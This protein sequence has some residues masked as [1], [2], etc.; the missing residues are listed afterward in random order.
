MKY[1]IITAIMVLVA[2]CSDKPSASKPAKRQTFTDVV[3][4]QAGTGPQIEV[5]FY[6]GPSLYYPLM[7]VWLED[8]QGD[9][10]QTLFV[11]RAIATGVFKYGSNASGKWEEAAKRAPQTLPY[12]SHRRGIR[13]SDGLYMPDP[14][15][16]V[17]D[18]YSGA[19]PTTS[20][21]LQ[22]RA[23]KAL[24]GKFRVMFEVN[25]NWDWNEYWTNDK[26]PDDKYYLSNAQPSLVYESLIDM[27]DMR[28]SYVMKPAGHGD[29]TGATGEL[30]TDLSSL[31]TALQIADS[32]V[33]RITE[34]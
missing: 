5:K 7:A 32:L 19:T 27:N 28:D 10:I 17:A 20:F 16:P 12:W 11:P 3:T 25:Q 2:S 34:K 30:F 22:T 13:A 9:Y 24:P 21:V 26:Y 8:E 6:G 33:V 29:P 14:E 1:L 4:N 18:A 15:N 23:D 31:T